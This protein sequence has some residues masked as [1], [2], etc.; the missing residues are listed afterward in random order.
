MTTE[1]PYINWEV[2]ATTESK[3]IEKLKM[4][5]TTMTATRQ[6]PKKVSKEH[7]VT[8]TT[9]LAQTTRKEWEIRMIKSQKAISSAALVQLKVVH[10]TLVGEEMDNFLELLDCSE[11]EGGKILTTNLLIKSKMFGLPIG[12]T[13]AVYV[14]RWEE[15]EVVIVPLGLLDLQ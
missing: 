8:L 13:V 14:A 9:A 4:L 10:F 3:G 2:L 12:H 5:F 6:I 1:N 11:L 7:L 15:E